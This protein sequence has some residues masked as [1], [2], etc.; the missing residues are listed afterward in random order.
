MAVLKNKETKPFVELLYWFTIFFT[1]GFLMTFHKRYAPP[2]DY[3]LMSVGSR[4]AWTIGPAMFTAF[5]LWLLN[6]LLRLILGK[7]FD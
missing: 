5:F 2:I 6:S 1:F 4:I 3:E 7:L